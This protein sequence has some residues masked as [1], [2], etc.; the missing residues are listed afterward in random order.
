MNPLE[1]SILQFVNATGY[2]PV[3]PRGIAQ[4]LKLPT[5]QVADVKQTI[6]R[7]VRRKQIAY[8]PNH[9]VLPIGEAA[10]AKPSA[11]APAARKRM[12][13]VFQRRQKGF[14]FVRLTGEFAVADAKDIY[15]RP[16]APATPPRATW[17]LWS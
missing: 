17:S 12:T 9:L 13:G 15:I 5:E 8:G 14:G 1:Q 7:L 6:K 16:I 11:A 4:Q 2:R 10:A 3:K